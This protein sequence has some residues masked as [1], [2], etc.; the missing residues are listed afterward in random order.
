MTL[1]KSSLLAGE[2]WRIWNAAFSIFYRS[3]DVFLAPF[4]NALFT[5]CRLHLPILISSGDS[6]NSLLEDTR[7]KKFRL[8]LGRSIEI[9]NNYPWLRAEVL[10]SK[11]LRRSVLV[12]CPKYSDL[13][14]LT[15]TSLL[16]VCQYLIIIS[17]LHVWVTLFRLSSKNENSDLI[18]WYSR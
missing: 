7:S 4:L 2:S 11:L 9:C 17:T 16:R 18:Y 1:V 15:F 8:T 6:S 5:I 14:Y 13:Q 3:Q 10:S 12:V